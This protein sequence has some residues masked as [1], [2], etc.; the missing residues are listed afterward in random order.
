LVSPELRGGGFRPRQL[1]RYVSIPCE[2]R[3]S[4]YDKTNK[5]LSFI[6]IGSG[7]MFVL[8]AKLFAKS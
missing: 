6:H 7:S 1:R 8:L 4:F 5:Q 2:F 3:V